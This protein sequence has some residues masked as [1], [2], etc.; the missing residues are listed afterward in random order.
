M[1]KI[2]WLVCIAVCIIACKQEAEPVVAPVVEEV[3]PEVIY[4]QV[5]VD[6]LRGR[7]EPGRKSEVITK[8]PEGTVVKSLD[9]ASDFKDKIT[10][11]GKEHNE[12][13]RLVELEDGKQVWLYGGALK[14]YYAGPEMEAPD[15]VSDLQDFIK[16]LATDQEEAG[17]LLLKKL[18]D[19]S[20]DDAATNDML[21]FTSWEY[22]NK[23]A[24]GA[25]QHA[26]S[27]LAWVDEHYYSYIADRSLDMQSNPKTIRLSE[28]GLRLEASEGMAY[29]VPD[30][31]AL[32]GAIGGVFTEGTK[33]Y[34]RLLDNEY[35]HRLF[36][37]AAIA[38][39][40][41]D[42]ADDAIAWSQFVKKYPNHPKIDWA[43]SKAKQYREVVLFG[44]ENTP[45]FSYDKQI[46]EPEFRKMWQYIAKKYNR[47]ELGGEVEGF[48][49]KTRNN[50]WKLNV[51]IQ[52]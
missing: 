3:V 15:Q 48:Y 31:T 46:A 13:Y 27:T 40:M 26:D 45:A 37:D 28:R 24:D 33:E 8:I 52:K 18:L 2:A 41:N 47:T 21:L 16:N 35:K 17:N 10:L 9:K 22:L 34:I 49:N 32:D 14:K 1:K 42:L 50:G 11:R 51:R 43:K 12:P 38:G 36:S 19:L 4:Y 30:I 6:K 29:Y 23:L 39:N 20:T 7:S 44:T 25:S 5:T